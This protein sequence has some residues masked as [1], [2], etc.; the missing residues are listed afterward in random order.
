MKG[1]VAILIKQSISYSV[2][3]PEPPNKDID[4]NVQ[5]RQDDINETDSTIE[6][7][8]INIRTRFGE[9]NLINIYNKPQNRMNKE[10]YIKIID[11]IKNNCLIVGDFNGYSP[12]W[13]ADKTDQTGKCIEEI[14]DEC[15]LSV[16]NTGNGTHIK[17]NGSLSP[18]DLSLASNRL[19]L[20]C[21]WRV[22]NDS[23]GSDHL[24]IHITVNETTNNDEAA[25][26]IETSQ[27]RFNLKRADWQLFKQHCKTYLN[28][29]VS[30]TNT[31]SF[32]A[33]I[34]GSILTA[35]EASIPS[36]NKPHRKKY[37]PYWNS[38]C[39]EAVN[40]KKLAEQRM[41]HTKDLNDCIEY[42][43]CKGIAQR[44]LKEAQKS[45]WEDYC[46]NLTSDSKLGSVWRM[47]KRMVGVN[48][49]QTIP[50][51][52]DETKTY[53]S[54]TEKANLIAQTFAHTSSS[55]NYTDTFRIIKAEKETE[56]KT[57]ATANTQTNNELNEF[58]SLN[59]LNSAI[60]QCKNKSS[61]GQ[62]NI[63]YE[64]IKQIPKSSLR[65]LLTMYNQLWAEGR[66]LQDW[67]EA[68]VIPIHKPGTDAS[69][70]GSYRPISLTSVLCKIMERLITNRLIWY[71]EKYNL[72]NKDQSGYRRNRSTMDQ[73]IRIHDNINKSINTKGY[74]LGVFI[75]F[76]K[77]YDMLWR[78]G[79]LYKI[80]KL[81]LSGNI[82]SWIEDFL[83]GRT[84]KVKIGNSFDLE[85]GTPQGS[86]ISP[87][88]FLLMINDIPSDSDPNTY[89]SLF[90]DDSAIW[91]SGRHIDTLFKEIQKQLNLFHEWCSNW[92][93]KINE[94]KTV[95]MIFTKKQNINPKNLEITINNVQIKLVSTVKFLG[96][97][98]DSKLSWNNHIQYLTDKSKPKINLLRSLS[99]HTWGASKKAMICIYRALVRS[100]LDYGSQI[101]HTASKSAL[102]K[103]QMIQTTCLR[104]SCGAM[105]T[106]PANALQQ[107]CGEMP[108]HL[109]RH[110]L[111]LQYTIKIKANI[112][113]PANS[114]LKDT[115]EN[116]Y[117]KYKQG[118][119]PVYNLTHTF[120]KKV[121]NI[122]QFHTSEQPIWHLPL[123]NTDLSL[124]KYVSKKDNSEILKSYAMEHINKFTGYTHIYTDGSKLTSGVTGASFFDKTND[125]KQCVRLSNNI[126]IYTA[127]L[128]AIQLAM[129]W[130]ITKGILGKVAIFSD[131]LSAIQSLETGISTSKPN[132]LLS[133]RKLLKQIN[134]ENR[135]EITFSWIP[136]HVGIIG[137]EMADT[138]A[139]LATSKSQVE[140][141]LPREVKDVYSDIDKHIVNT[142][143]EEYNKSRT[144]AHY[145]TIEPNGN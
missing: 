53:H 47:A 45:C 74:T 97:I 50:S 122:E 28:K 6:A 72:L 138:L 136:S 55:Q 101:F 18:I 59:E 124:H 42:R 64:M 93:F 14:I 78:E 62:D 30:S 44:T 26:I 81:G 127:E 29:S 102:D 75:D 118:S 84:I 100:R 73:L 5:T 63:S 4:A 15:N 68:V 116:H 119:E 41:R 135:C 133:V 95:A 143:Q 91:R 37:V 106:T 137:N 71:L 11:P 145:K 105:R 12:M 34:V 128:I 23:M 92:G 61:P 25:D 132:L 16:L 83:T 67:K 17:N 108:L 121:G 38:K 39:S 58:F 57:N 130:L 13:G 31:N 109:R 80:R 1:G 79:L 89:C 33:N 65:I 32:Y 142:W 111:L 56:W 120:L 76:S 141:D 19:A 103:L 49:N 86:V 40:N 27:T 43:R 87:I 21:N 94:D 117:G 66:V 88:L 54:A 104:L 85:N 10:A 52:S 77:A 90:A 114:V 113:N 112:N 48:T 125:E 7:I 24:P 144:G 20:K 60:T 70:P 8:G 36:S 110:K 46:S 134:R 82:Y 139:K 129:Q 2:I 126:T 99:G 51:L 69:L 35:A 96:L 22:L 131:S 123:G 107:E 9:M 3:K 98:F 140:I 115:W